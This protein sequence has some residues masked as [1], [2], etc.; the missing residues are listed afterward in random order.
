VILAA[1]CWAPLTAEAADRG[2]CAKRGSKTVTAD[3]RGRVFYVQNRFE[4]RRYYGCLYRIG[5][6]FPI[7][8]NPHDELNTLERVVLASPF[9]AYVVASPASGR[10]NERLDRVDLR[11]GSF[12]G[13]A[14]ESDDRLGRHVLTRSGAMAWTT[15]H[16]GVNRFQEVEK[17]DA[18]G[19]AILDSGPEL[20]PAS[21]ALSRAS[22]RVYWMNAGSAR[23]ARLR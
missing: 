4:E 17:L 9:V 2:K 10:S 1:L 20:D 12:V 22:G 14:S 7:G 16:Y 11:T 23:S 15:L 19:E 18:D 3:K 5:R 8:D 6:R 21:L 13:V